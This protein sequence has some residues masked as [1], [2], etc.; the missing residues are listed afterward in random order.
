MYGTCSRCGSG[1][2]N[3]ITIKGKI[4][5]TTCAEVVLDKRLP[6]DFSY[7]DYD[8]YL[9]DKADKVKEWN[10]E[11]ERIENITDTNWHILQD[12]SRALRNARRNSNEWQIKFVYSIA[13]TFF[14]GSIS[15]YG[16]DKYAT[17]DEAIENWNQDIMGSFPYIRRV[18]KLSERQEEIFNKILNT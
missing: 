9:S 15:F 17:M 4:Y 1:I 5:G 13:R 7:G 12:V 14:G 18:N 3:I 2:K 6:R 11:N 10:E 8:K 16:C